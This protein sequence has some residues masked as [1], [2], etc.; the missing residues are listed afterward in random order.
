MKTNIPPPLRF[1]KFP[2]LQSL[3][4]LTVLLPG[5]RAF[6]EGDPPPSP[7]FSHQGRLAVDGVLVN[8]NRE[9]KFLLF[10]RTGTDPD[11]VE[12]PI[13]SNFGIPEEVKEP[14]DSVSVAVT[15]GLYS[16]VIGDPQ[17]MTP[18]PEN[19]AL[20][21]DGKMFLRIWIS[22]IEASEFFQLTPDQEITATPFALCA[23]TLID[24]AVTSP[25]I[26]DGEVTTPDIADGAV[27]AEK[28]G[29]DAVSGAKIADGSID[30]WD[31][32]ALSV[33]NFHLAANAIT[34]NKILD[35]TITSADLGA[36][37]VDGNRIVDGSITSADLGPNA[38]DGNRIVD[39]TI[40]SAD[41]GPNA[42]DG[43]RIVDASIT[44][45][46]LSNGSVDGN[47]IVDGTIT[48]ADLGPNAVDGNR[49]VDASISA[50]DLS[51]NS[52]NGDKI[53]DGSITAADLGPNAVDG[54]RIVDASIGSADLGLG[55]V[56]GGKIAD[57][58]IAAADLALGA[59]GTGALAP[60]AV[61]GEKL[62]SNSVAGIHLLDSSITAADIQPG[63]VEESLIA[64]AAVTTTKMADASITF[65]KFH[66]DTVLT[67]SNGVPDGGVTTVKLAT[68][69]VTAEKLA[70][71]SVT[72]S[73]LASGAVTAQALAP[74]AV[75]GLDNPVPGEPRAVK[76]LD[77]GSMQVGNGTITDGNTLYLQQAENLVVGGSHVLS[78]MRSIVSGDGHDIDAEYALVTGFQNEVTGISLLVA[79]AGHTVM[80]DR[81][82]VAG[83]NH[84]VSG[85]NSMAVGSSNTVDANQSVAIGSE[86]QIPNAAHNSAVFGRGNIS[87]GPDSCVM[88]R[89]NA[90]NEISDLE[91]IFT[92]G[93]GTGAHVWNRRN[94]FVVGADGKLAIGDVT[95]NNMFNK[96]ILHANGAYLTTGGTWTN[97]SDR[98]IKENIRPVDSSELLD[99]LAAL[100][101]SEWNYKVE[102]DETRHVG[103]MAQDFQEAFGLGDSDKAISTVDASGVALAAIQA[104]KKQTDEQAAALKE[105]DR[106]IA[107]LQSRMERL[108]QEL[109]SVRKANP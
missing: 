71:E 61:T 23:R 13:W 40:T 14:E 51:S 72:S 50:L 84:L 52:V 53:V 17:V 85:S 64:D 63:S 74:G 1:L 38:V 69:A 79:G 62:S 100:P 60:A 18:L 22:G 106:L 55:S 78:A 68:A 105:R 24:D 6:A 107:D 45:S 49:I 26:R 2:V 20:P 36:N 29:G 87:S 31:I 57:G 42:V 80:G 97:A 75:T 90:G 46:D 91:P 8:G 3:M 88:G 9:F 44:S 103:P 82:L 89:Y 66:P 102:D 77:N 93:D 67:L 30:T 99:K 7:T 73:A 37:A 47:K 101:I 39:G 28:L 109:K 95:A 86:C 10:N 59:V 11:F 98:N 32:A 41:L 25:K 94:T 27:T 108:E 104:L 56:D 70:N 48:S 65:S 4:C 58:S 96:S 15:N 54:N 81:L 34:G 19:L 21:P 35:G 12:T 16:V 5:P 76:I 83:A 43:N 92:V 33:Q